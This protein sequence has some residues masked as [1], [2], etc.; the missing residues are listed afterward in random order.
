[1]VGVT[2]AIAA[3]GACSRF[4]QC[5]T[6]AECPATAYCDVKR[7]LCFYKASDGGA[8]AEVDAGSDAGDSGSKPPSGS[9]DTSFGDGGFV[10]LDFGAAGGDAVRAL[11]I[12]VAGKVIAVGVIDGQA[13]FFRLD[14]AGR[15]DSTFTDGGAL[16]LQLSANGSAAHSVQVLG[17][18]RFVAS[19][20]NYESA[21]TNY[22]TLSKH[23]ANGVLDTAFGASGL[24][25]VGPTTSFGVFVSC[26]V[27][28]DGNLLLATTIPNGGI[29]PLMPRS[30]AIT[31]CL[32]NGSVDPTFGNQ[33]TVVVT[34]PTAAAQGVTSVA[35]QGDGRI[36]VGLMT[37]S[38]SF[39][40][41]VGFV[42]RFVAFGGVDNSFGSGGIRAMSDPSDAGEL[43]SVNAVVVVAGGKPVV[44][45]GWRAS[46]TAK[47]VPRISRLN[48]SGADDS[49]F[50]DG[51][52]T[53]IAVLA[54]FTISSVATTS[55]GRIGFLATSISKNGKCFVGRFQSDGS[56]DLTFGD[57][58]LTAV[59][60]VPPAQC[61]SLAIGADGRFVFSATESLTG[62]TGTGVVSRVVP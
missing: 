21:T 53:V 54:D 12:D 38:E 23:L 39:G 14:Q 31:R 41:S 20:N 45:G 44:G 34:P 8:D 9:F 33:G 7:E 30:P 55:D 52:N 25:A 3:S 10:R 2:G 28:P 57:G 48:Q 35:V 43:S 11:A 4:T 36:T 1:M 46:P 42:M 13:G 60:L 56:L 29:S 37:G 58:G 62:D 18:G 32:P 5:K 59:E 16:R 49:S 24:A 19:I 6:D 61:S 22:P 17:D 51:G 50:G 47:T 15:L 26:A 27:Q 40:Q